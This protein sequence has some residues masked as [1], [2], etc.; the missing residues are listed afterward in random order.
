MLPS[1]RQERLAE[2]FVDY[3]AQVSGP[4]ALSLEDI[5]EAITKDPT[6]QAVTD[7]VHTSNWFE[8]SKRLDI[9]QHAYKAFEK[10]KEAL[11]N[12]SS[13]G[14][15]LRQRQTLVP[16]TLQQTVFD[17]AHLRPSHSCRKKNGFRASTA[18]WR[19]K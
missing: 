11:T 1:S 13:S 17:L 3:I 16:E 19:R 9:N 8:P 12:C 5:A 10:G 14:V 7:A 4:N 15:I 6:L 18:K 2:E